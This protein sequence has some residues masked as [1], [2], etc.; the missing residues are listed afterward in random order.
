MATGFDELNYV[1][2]TLELFDDGT[3]LSIIVRRCLRL[4]H[5]RG[6]WKSLTW[7]ELEQH[8]F[9]GDKPRDNGLAAD[10]LRDLGRDPGD[11]ERIAIVE[12]FISR[13]TFDD[14][15]DVR[16]AGLVSGHSVELLEQHIQLFDREIASSAA[17][18]GGSHLHQVDRA[19]A[20]TRLETSREATRSTLAKVRNAVFAFLLRTE[21]ELIFVEFNDAFFART[22]ALVDRH[23]SLVSADAVERFNAAYRRLKDGDG[24]SLSQAAASCR[25]VLHAL[26]DAVCPARSDRPLD[27]RGVPR[28]LTADKYRNRL[29]WFVYEVCPKTTMR[30]LL[31]ADVK[32][33]SDRLEALDS[34]SGK[35]VHDA[36][37]AQE[38]EALASHVYLVAAEILNLH[39]R[40]GSAVASD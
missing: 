24:E 28:D 23:L 15:A 13:R 16:N 1:R 34:L 18:V 14:R 25:R 6:D 17:E 11:A 3:P 21:R 5:A 36:V 38:A 2:E 7:L 37:S 35:G 40:F 26:A 30:P 10:L 4:A 9:G 33:M 19:T 12:E 27:S 31:D 29:L 20:R 32:L 39:E 22:K 8:E